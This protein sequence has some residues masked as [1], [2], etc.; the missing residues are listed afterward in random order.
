MKYEKML[1]F[2]LQ[3]AIEENKPVL[4]PFGNLE[5]H[6]YHLP[7]GCDAMNAVF[8]LQEIEKKHTNEVILMPPFYYGTSSYAVAGS[9]KGTISIDSEIIL[10]FAEELFK[11]LLEIGFRNIHCFVAHQ[12]ENFYQGMPYDLSLRLAARRAIF[13]FMEKEKGQGWWGNK[14]T[15]S[16]YEEKENIFDSIQVHGEPE[17][18]LEV[19]GGDHAGKLETSSVMYMYPEL[20]RMDLRDSSEDWFAEKAVYANKEYGEK[21][22]KD[23]IAIFENMIFK[24]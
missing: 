19:F 18:I 13:S 5:Y 17:Q 10:K 21:Y 4:I 11:N 6:S 7:F 16:Y 24:K 2:E 15:A 3:K 12:T 1:P 22:I 23:K 8:P 9:K 20:V 14:E